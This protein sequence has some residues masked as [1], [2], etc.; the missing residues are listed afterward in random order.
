MQALLLTLALPGREV[1]PKKSTELRQLARNYLLLWVV[2]VFKSRCTVICGPFFFFF[3][4]MMNRAFKLTSS[5]LG[6]TKTLG[7]APSSAQKVSGIMEPPGSSTLRHFM[8]SNPDFS[9]MLT[10]Q[11]LLS[12]A[13]NS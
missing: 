11:T 10:I 6:L 1:S 12:C 8:L 9:V 13:F 2:M 4:Q 5:S 3:L 7:F